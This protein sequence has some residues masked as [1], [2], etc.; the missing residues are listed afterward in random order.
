MKTEHARLLEEIAENTVRIHR[1]RARPEDAYLSPE[2]VGGYL[3]AV[4]DDNAAFGISEKLTRSTIWQELLKEAD[5]DELEHVGVLLGLAFA[6]PA[7]ETAAHQYCLQRLGKSLMVAL[8]GAVKQRVVA[9]LNT[10]DYIAHAL[11][12]YNRRRRIGA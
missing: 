1:D 3:E 10:A 12:T 4:I 9:D 7:I 5:A 2:F 11:F 6:T 8:T